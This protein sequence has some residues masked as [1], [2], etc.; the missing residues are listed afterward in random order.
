MRQNQPP[1]V[2][3]SENEKYKT[4]CKDYV[5]LGVLYFACLLNVC[6]WAYASGQILN[7][8]INIQ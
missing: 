7:S 3:F 8:L 4:D 5:Y 1:I 2:L 6:L